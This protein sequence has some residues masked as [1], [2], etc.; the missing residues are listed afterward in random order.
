MINI[1]EGWTKH[2]LN[3]F[4]LTEVPQFAQYRMSECNKCEWKNNDMCKAC[5]CYLPAKT[6]VKSENCPLNKWQQSQ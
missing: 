3:E 6:L 4:G 2:I 5:G 1:L